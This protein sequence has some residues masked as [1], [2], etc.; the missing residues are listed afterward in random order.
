[1]NETA[2][3]VGALNLAGPDDRNFHP[4][5]GGLLAVQLIHVLPYNIIMGAQ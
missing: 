4:G 3:R 1:M 2:R 5:K